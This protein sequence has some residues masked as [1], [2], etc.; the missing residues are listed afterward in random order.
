MCHLCQWTL[1]TKA[2]GEG[3]RRAVKQAKE[4]E[5]QCRQHQRKHANVEDEGRMGFAI[6]VDLGNQ[7]SHQKIETAS[8]TAD[9]GTRHRLLTA[10]QTRCALN[11]KKK[12]R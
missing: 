4:F 10:E 7:I 2:F 12:E 3:F 5:R 8:Y 6:A 11:A 9:D 1:D